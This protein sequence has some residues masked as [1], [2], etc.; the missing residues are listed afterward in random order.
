MQV[1]TDTRRFFYEWWY[2]LIKIAKF[3]SSK[4][5][6]VDLDRAGGRWSW[7]FLFFGFECSGYIV[8]YSGRR[9]QGFKKTYT[10]LS[11]FK[12]IILHSCLTWMLSL[13]KNFSN[14]CS[15]QISNNYPSFIFSYFSCFNTTFCADCILWLMLSILMVIGELTTH[16][17]VT[18]F[19]HRKIVLCECVSFD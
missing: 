16:F 2:Y 1:Q 3:V 12:K 7:N 6:S 14:Q 15:T 11:L 9:R 17:S 5:V 18:S 8:W 19:L 10:K 13:T 4:I